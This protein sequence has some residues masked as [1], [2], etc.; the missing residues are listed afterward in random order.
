MKS[1]WLQHATLRLASLLVSGNQRAEWLKGWH[2]EF[3]YIP[4]H[5][6][7]RFC[8]GAFR[9]A[10]W[11]RRNSERPAGHSAFWFESP[12]SCLAFL[13]FAATVSGALM[14]CLPA[15]D[16]GGM[17][18]FPATF[19]LPALLTTGRGA[20]SHRPAPWPNRLRRGIFLLLKF[21]LVQPVMLCGFVIMIWIGPAAGPLSLLV[22][23]AYYAFCFLT[24]RWVLLDQR[25]RC[26]VCLRLLTEPV[27]I[28]AL[29][30]TF[31][32]WYG[33]ESACPCGHG[34]LQTSESP[35]SY[36]AA[37]EWHRLDDSWSGLF[38]PAAEARHR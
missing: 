30:Q 3:W 29:S 37:P 36:S 22:Q 1:A 24:L 15:P 8:L 32:E 27:R 13:T 4:R 17:L 6:A 38:S 5:G 16:V 26:P 10:I 25:N 7:A 20:S 9:D 28:G 18:L 14:V 12:L 11:V 19:L 31:L 2:S 21:A 23:L 34:L 35:S 33:S